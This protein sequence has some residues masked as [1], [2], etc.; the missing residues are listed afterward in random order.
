MSYVWPAGLEPLRNWLKVQGVDVKSIVSERQAA[1]YV[2]KL[3]DQRFKFPADR[4]APLFPLL[5]RLQDIICAGASTSRPVPTRGQP[6]Q[7]KKKGRRSRIKRDRKRST[8]S[9]PDALVI[10]CD[11]CCEPN[12]G[13][14]GWGYA[15]YRDGVEI[16]ARFGGTATATNNQMELTGL[17][18]A[19]AWVTASA[20]VERVVIF[21]DSQYAVTGL[22][23]WVPGWKAKGW[24]RKGE[25]ASEKN[26]AIA[27]LDLWKLIDKTRD[28][29][30]FVKVKWVKG[31]A[32]TVGNE[33]ADELAG[34]GRA[35][36]VPVTSLDLIRQQLDYSA[37]V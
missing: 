9:P 5:K 12:P 13:V 20:T 19:L 26:K 16:D 10:Y 8:M 22:N 36:A 24:N 17:L 30:P 27:N 7:S 18:M 2:Q 37:R 6:F 35:E 31:H 1:F 34:M 4:S 15:V 11:G 23:Q 33:R 14:G 3:S 28:E 21:C 25:N 29:L 32:G